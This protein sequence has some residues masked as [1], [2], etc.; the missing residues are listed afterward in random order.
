MDTLKQYLPLCWFAEN[1]LDLPRSVRFFQQ[2]LW[3]YFIL[4]LFIQLNMID[5]FE[6]VFEVILETGLTLLFVGTMLFLNRSTSTYVTV[7]SAVLFCENIIAVFVVPV[8]VW[9][10][11]AEDEFSYIAMLLLIVWDY[12]LVAFVFKKVL[13]INTAAGCVISLAYFLS[14]YGGAYLITTLLIG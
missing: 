1:P 12:A 5:S 13:G 3:F 4:E 11:I 6:A 9:L 14:T 2:N 7:A 8:M 10:T